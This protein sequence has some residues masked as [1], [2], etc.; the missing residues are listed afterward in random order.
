VQRCTTSFAPSGIG[1]FSP[2]SAGRDDAADQIDL[3][4]V[5]ERV[6]DENGGGMEGWMVRL[7]ERRRRPR[8]AVRYPALP[9]RDGEMTPVLPST[10]RTV[11]LSARRRTYFRL[12]EA[13]FVG[14]VEQ[15]TVAGRRLGVALL[16]R[17][18]CDGD[19]RTCRRSGR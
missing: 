15:Q 19:D 1:F 11:W 14:L 12:V 13:D 17:R 8:P 10:R 7:I 6:A 5:V 16:L 4:A 18:S 9:S 2:A 3:Q